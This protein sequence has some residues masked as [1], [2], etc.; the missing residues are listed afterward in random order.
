MDLTS[1]SIDALRAK[2][3]ARFLEAIVDAARSGVSPEA[4]NAL[5]AVHRARW[6]ARGAPAQAAWLLA[7]WVRRDG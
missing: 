5:L 6:L 3:R 4:T 1:S 7:S 2:L